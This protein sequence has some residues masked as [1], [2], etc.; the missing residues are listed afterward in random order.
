MTRAMRGQDVFIGTYH[1]V[2]E[3]DTYLPLIINNYSPK[4]KEILANIY[5]DYNCFSIIFRCEHKKSIDNERKRDKQRTENV[6]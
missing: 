4:A 2:H 5:H 1:D 6:T 3:Q